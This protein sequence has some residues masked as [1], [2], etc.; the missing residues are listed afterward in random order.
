MIT[1]YGPAAFA[2]F[3]LDKLQAD[4]AAHKLV[5]RFVHF[6]D[7]SLQDE[8][9]VALEHLLDYG[10]KADETTYDNY[11]IIVPRIGT[12][13]PW[14]SKATDIAN[15][16]GLSSVKRIERGVIFYTDRVIPADKLPILYD[17]MTEQV[18]SGID[19]ATQIFSEQKPRP[20]VTVPMFE[21]GRSALEEINR[22]L[23]LA[24]SDEEIDY[25]FDRFSK[26][27]RDPTDVEL[28]M[29]AQANSEH[30]RH[31]IFN[32]QWS[33]DGEIQDKSLF[34]MIKNTYQ[35]NS[36]GVLSAYHDN[37]A[38]LKG[39]EV[40]RFFA[41]PGNNEYQEV[42]E[43][44]DI[45]IKAETH[46]HPTAIA[47]FPGSGTGSGGEIRDEG[48]TGRGA[49]PKAGLTGFSVSNLQIPGFEQPWEKPYGKPD[50]I[51]SPLEIMT[52]GP[53][54]AAAYNN[55]FGR[56]GLAGYFRTFEHDFKGE[57][58]GYHK[59]IMVGGG[60]A[61]IRHKDVQKKPIPDKA[62]LVVLGGPAMLIGLGGGAAS[63]Q[64]TGQ[65]SEDL[66]YASVQ[67]QNPEMQRRAQEVIN[68]CWS[69][70][71]N[72]ILSI[73]DVG[74]GGW[75][76]ALPEIIKDAGRGGVID[77]AN[78]PNADSSLSPM[79]LWSNESQERYVLAIMEND[80]D[81][82]TKI[83]ER[84]RCIFAVVGEATTEQNLLV[85]LDD[86]KPVD[87]PMDL[88]FGSSPKLHIE[89]SKPNSVKDELDLSGIN[90]RDALH[91]VLSLPA[92]ASKSFLITIGDRT[93]GGLI[94]RDQM[95]GP[96][97]VPVAD[98]AV[99][100]SDF[101]SN[102]GEALA[103]GERTPLAL[104]SGPA[105]ARMAI[106]EL[107][108]NMAAAQIEK[109]SDIKLSANW[110]AASGLNDE[111]WNL[112]QTVK[113]V[114]EE[115][116]P[117]LG[118]TIPVGKDSLSMKTQWS[119]N[120]QNKSVTSPLS[121]IISGFAPVQDTAKSLTP[122]LAQAEDTS[123]VLIDLSE[124]KK[125]L[126]GSAL[127]QVYSQLGSDIP[128]AEN[129][130]TILEF[131]NS[132]Q[133]LNQEGK[134]LAYHD[135]SDGGLITTVLEM[136]F[137]GRV[138]V[139]LDVD[140]SLDNLFNEELGAVIQVRN[141]DVK[142]VVAK[143]NNAKVIGSPISDLSLQ[144]GGNEFDVIEMLK[145]WS[146]T[147]YR[148]QRLRDNP[149]TADSEYNALQDK[150]NPGLSSSLTFEVPSKFNT[151]KIRPKVAILREQGVN[152]HVEM[153]AAF[154]K[155]GFRA[156]D[157][158]MTDLISGR[159]KLSDFVGLAAGGGFSYGDVLGAGGGWAKSILF[160]QDLHHQ[161]REFFEREDTFSI[162]ICNGCQMLSRLKSIIPGAH[163]W[164][165]FKQNISRRFEARLVMAEIVESPSI[166]FKG[167]AGSKIPVPTAHGEGLAKFEANS[168]PISAMRYVDNYGNATEQYP[169][170][171]NG[172][173]DGLTGFTTDDGRVTIIMPHPERTFLAKQFSWA[174]NEWG[175]NS[176]WIQIFDNARNFVS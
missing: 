40:N 163:D 154:S 151:F 96:W 158:H 11:V 106:G 116:C 51:V 65:Q 83:C 52:Q 85:K 161:F 137:A 110:M 170:N 148:I 90:L 153:A 129:A 2:D 121:L 21:N 20:L 156:V 84:E 91:R 101:N 7:G 29:F 133:K 140:D 108:T 97:Q 149:A 15:N 131:F 138:G 22:E 19:Q 17:R 168:S 127:A 36:E 150:L 160:N 162:G 74:A 124:G 86:K 31:K 72:P 167:M 9:K 23:G 38:V 10:E 14:S 43:Q 59:P 114:G 136:C 111:D 147:S 45:V 95:V 176:P 145:V 34:A 53:L 132:I 122:Q 172:S 117:E 49:K 35:K 77:L 109:I 126:G 118:L 41:N 67:R 128:D 88:I 174:P 13:S 6:V 157:V 25:L 94:V 55:E 100:A 164:P 135:R 142:E 113:A 81:R 47:P 57:V 120:G 66:D 139:K 123:L 78:L 115:F 143:F 75:S 144:V 119:E 105:S 76:N 166:I 69:S 37:G 42:T 102:Y 79:E 48:S 26:L 98:V 33:L 27:K 71:V 159:Q 12:L 44:T 70:D 1:L 3:E 87:V 134:L 171:P 30:C 58:R 152:G 62:K 56:T 50:R 173:Q 155:V 93:V 130:G 104:V 68:A 82:F 169:F 73:H 107:I 16:S 89:A 24:V 63:S 61:A 165:E 146:Q 99:M 46:N 5:A 141:S 18:I 80:V 112:Y 92:V 32:A 125:R 28:M 60:L 4:L 8:E 39:F 103:M 54:G 175:E 64:K